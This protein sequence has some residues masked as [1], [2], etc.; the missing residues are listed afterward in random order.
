MSDIATMLAQ[1]GIGAASGAPA[2]VGISANRMTEQ[3]AEMLKALEANTAYATDV[4]NLT[5]GGALSIQSLDK[6]MH[7]VT[8]EQKHF[9]FFKA[10]R[11]IG[12]GNIVDEYTRKIGIGGAP[13][14]SSMT[15]MGVVRPATGE[16]EREVG[17][18]KFLATLRQVSYIL[19][20]GNNIA[21]P[22]AQE[23][24]NGTL[25]LLTDLEWLCF[26]GNAS[27][28]PTQFDGIIHILEAAYT[29]GN[30]ATDHILNMDATPLESLEP[31]AKI[32]AAAMKFGSF[33]HVTDAWLTN[34]IQT[35]L[36]NN[37][38][39]AARWS[40][41]V[42]LQMN[43]GTH[44]EGIR[45]Q[46]GVLKTQTNMFLPYDGFPMMLPFDES[47]PA[48]GTANAAIKPVSVTIAAAS[49][50]ASMF[51]AARAGNY[52]WA[53]A[54]IDHEGKLMSKVT[55]SAQTAITTGQKATLT[56]TASSAATES[57]Y[58]IY[59]S[60][61]DGT[62]AT[63]DL[64]LMAVVAKS[65]ATTT[66]VDLNREIPGTSKVPVLSMDAASGSIDWRQ[67]GNMTKI[68][69]P[70]GVGGQLQY[71][72]FQYVGGYLRVTKPEHHGLITNV[73]PRNAQWR[74]FT[75]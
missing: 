43:I 16:Y 63:S 18:A 19:N 41:Q 9:K 70:F 29:A 39:P 54:G 66:Y 45:L 37:L 8:Q 40:P 10:L 71:S 75:A 7:A 26:T 11:S 46:D 73:L 35:D 32:G 34:D 65:G 56:I 24:I 27:A 30:I 69:L 4:D 50:A 15:A 13:G 57:G 68:P 53:V 59:R 51:T 36:N 44:V 5:G 55:L 6:T 49:D 20:L 17:F 42:G 21:A 3:V 23:E 31:F 47:Y 58:A 72:W 62:N 48:I 33:G 52:Y 64:R 28:S 12:V 67:F 60:R 61:Q 74:P 38:D 2:G 14:G 25:Q 22:M 1:L